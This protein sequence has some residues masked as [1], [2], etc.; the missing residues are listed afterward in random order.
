MGEEFNVE[1]R[2]KGVYGKYKMGCRGETWNELRVSGSD[3]LGVSSEGVGPVFHDWPRQ[4]AFPELID[5]IP[6][7]KCV[8]FVGRG[9]L[10]VGRHPANFGQSC[11]DH[12]PA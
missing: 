1:N 12:P 8:M 11:I 2:V 7:V 3:S 10:Q 6:R 4:L 9:Q 5:F